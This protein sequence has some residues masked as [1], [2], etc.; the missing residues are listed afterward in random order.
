MC[1]YIFT[2]P[3]SRVFR[4]F[5]RQNLSEVFVD[6]VIWSMILFSQAISTSLHLLILSDL[7]Q[8]S[9]ET[10]NFKTYFIET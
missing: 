10:N 6:T 1:I 7:S 5:Q 9:N 8:N 2:P 3:L 4:I